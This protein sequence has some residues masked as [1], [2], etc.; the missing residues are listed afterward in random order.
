M[1]GRLKQQFRSLGTRLMGLYLALLLIPVVGIG[2]YGHLYIQQTLAQRTFQTE[3]DAVSQGAQSIQTLLSQVDNDILYLSQR[4]AFSS[5]HDPSRELNG[6]AAAHPVYNNIVWMT[7]SGEQ[8]GGHLSD[9]LH[10]QIISRSFQEIRPNS[11]H[12]APL[13]ELGQEP[14]LMAIARLSDSVLLFEINPIYLLQGISS[15]ALG[16]WAVFI[17]P[18]TIL[19]TGEDPTKFSRISDEQVSGGQGYFSIGEDINLYAQTGPGNSWSLIRSMPGNTLGVDLSPYYTTFLFVLLGTLTA[20]AGLAMFAIS[21]MIEPVYQLEGMVDEVRHGVGRPALPE[22]VPEDEFGKLMNAFDQMAAELEQKRQ[23]ERALIEQ[24]I[25]A[26]EEERKLIAY[27]LHDGLIQQLVGARLYLGQCRTHCAVHVDETNRGVVRSYDVL[28][29][30]IAEGRRIIQGLHPTVLEDLGLEAAL[31]ELGN[32]MAETT[33]WQIDMDIDTLPTQPD[34][35]TS[36]TLYRITQEALNNTFKHAQASQVQ[37]RLHTMPECLQLFIQDD[38]CGFDPESI[39]QNGGQRWGI[40]TMQE[41]AHMLQGTCS[42]ISCPNEGT[43]IQVT[44]PH[45]E[46]RIKA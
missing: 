42:I 6:F 38:G 1:F 46:E 23:K 33:S 3:L 7:L 4:V 11:I 22:T 24:L 28:T 14:A 40:R 13:I 12:F 27:D 9:A 30:A 35:S 37:I 43:T 45:L 8:M 39:L 34:R 18:N 5:G 10:K 25:R 2:L 31:L 29:E 16:D 26:Q 15:Q 17:P 19:T 21:R 20:V 32:M 44:I 41:R 36:V